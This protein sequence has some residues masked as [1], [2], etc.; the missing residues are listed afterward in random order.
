VDLKF[1]IITAA[2]SFRNFNS[3]AALEL[4]PKFASESVP[5]GCANFG[6][7]TLA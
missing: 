5:Q 3:K 1:L 6:I 2:R 7:G 4:I